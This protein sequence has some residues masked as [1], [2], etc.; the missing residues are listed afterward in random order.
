MIINNV[1]NDYNYNF[2]L[3]KKLNILRLDYATNN[4]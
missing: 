3:K 2:F 4:Y 1:F